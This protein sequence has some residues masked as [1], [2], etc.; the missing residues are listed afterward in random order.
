MQTKT[1]RAPKLVSLLLIVSSVL[2]FFQSTVIQAQ[3][4]GRV[5][6]P[7]TFPRCEDKLAQGRGDRAA[8]DSGT[9]GVV[10]KGNLEGRD[11]VYT[12]PDGNFVQCFCPTGGGTGT[13]T[14]WWY[15]NG[16]PL[17]RVDIDAYVRNGWILQEN[18]ADWNL[19]AG[20]YLAKNSDFNCS[21]TG[22]GATSTPTVSPT[23]TPT[24][25]PTLTVT[26]PNES[27]CSDLVVSPREGTAPLTVQFTGKGNDPRGNIQE[28]EFDFGDASNNQRQV[29]TQT[30]AEIAHTYHNA[31]TYTAK[32]RIK[33]SQGNW[34]NGSGN[35]SKTITVK[36]A[37]TVAGSSDT[38]ELPGTG[39][40]LS[41]FFGLM[42]VAEVGYVVYKRFQI[43]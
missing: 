38:D 42:I 24:V 27:S 9:H 43:V 6:Q 33:D 14:D 4:T 2:F 10:G 29:V 1:I 12:L 25:T 28:Y 15:I 41:V 16:L 40:P 32:L 3:T 30:G 39:A 18:G 36:A 21:A 26:N 17:G 34:K 20:S 8:H 31:G 11:D 19:L 7:P 22:S 13:K 23:R 35:C 5:P 37:P